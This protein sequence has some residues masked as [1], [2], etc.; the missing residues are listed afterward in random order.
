MLLNSVPKGSGFL[1]MKEISGKP[2]VLSLYQGRQA[3]IDSTKS[4]ITDA[5]TVFAL[6]LLKALTKAESI[7]H[8]S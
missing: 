8:G 4:F 3:D 2:P 6:F 1:K 7:Y 5:A